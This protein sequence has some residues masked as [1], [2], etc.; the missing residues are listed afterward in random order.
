MLGFTRT[1]LDRR[2]QGYRILA[3]KASLSPS[4]PPAV[5]LRIAIQDRGAVWALVGI[6]VAN[7]IERA[8][9]LPVAAVAG[10]RTVVVA[11]AWARGATRPV[12]P[13]RG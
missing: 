6:V 10:A 12:L 11:A 8:E 3:G 13:A 4:L 5:G 9:N 2:P 1:A 7:T